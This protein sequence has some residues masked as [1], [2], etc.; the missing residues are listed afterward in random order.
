MKTFKVLKAFATPTRRFAVGADVSAEFVDGPLTLGDWQGLG[1][2]E[3]PTKV[4]AAA[5]A[6]DKKST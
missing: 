4:K 6:D 3:A 1:H 2:V 5:P